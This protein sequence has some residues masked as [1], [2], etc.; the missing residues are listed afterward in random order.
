M[1]KSVRTSNSSQKKHDKSLVGVLV[2]NKSDLQAFEKVTRSQGEEFAKEC[3]LDFFLTSTNTDDGNVEQPFLH[4]ADNFYK[5]FTERVEEIK[6][7]CEHKTA[8]KL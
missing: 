4:I 2:G 6:Y 5:S 3:G 1:C 7:V 8:H